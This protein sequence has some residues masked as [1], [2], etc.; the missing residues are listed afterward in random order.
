MNLA[1]IRSIFQTA[2]K[3]GDKPKQKGKRGAF[4]Q[5]LSE[6]A[7]DE[8]SKGEEQERRKERDTH[9]SITSKDSSGLH[10][11]TKKPTIKQSS[12]TK[13]LKIDLFA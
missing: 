7:K 3:V 9:R 4:E 6:E 5:E 1:S 12:D 8:D 11:L 10:R 13:G 2:Q